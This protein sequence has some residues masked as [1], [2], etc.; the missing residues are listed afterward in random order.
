MHAVVCLVVIEHL[1]RANS[2]LLPW[3]LR[4]SNSVISLLGHLAITS[5]TAGVEPVISAQGAE[6]QDCMSLRLRKKDWVKKEK[7]KDWHVG[8]QFLVVM[9]MGLVSNCCGHGLHYS[10][11]SD[12]FSD[13]CEP[14]PAQGLALYL[15]LMHAT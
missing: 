6:W 14:Q 2:L 7:A 3:G 13:L 4:A 1:A 8:V 9:V 11:S 10:L 5:S 12:L 15:G